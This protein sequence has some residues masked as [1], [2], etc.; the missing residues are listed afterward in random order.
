MDQTSLLQPVM[1]LLE[2]GGPVV[3]LIAVL[4]VVSLALVLMKIGQFWREGVGQN[5]RARNCVALW[6]SGRKQE[7]VRML[8]SPRTATEEVLAT[9]MRLSLTTKLDK[10]AI[11]EE[12]SRRAIARLHNQQWG[13]KAL[14]AIGQVAPLLGLFGTVLGMIEAFQQLQSAGNSVDPSMLAGGIWVA[15]LTTAAGLA[16][17]MPVSLILTFFESRIDNERVSIET[18]SAGILLSHVPDAENIK[19]EAAFQS[20]DPVS[21]APQAVHAH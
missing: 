8:S 3:A 20:A 19:V 12:V 17:A 1:N 13:L 2:T 9:A 15:L 21:M 14:D 18:L 7:A 10:A 6:R 11:E 5:R 4:S 16:V